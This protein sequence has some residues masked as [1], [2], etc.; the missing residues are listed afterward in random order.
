[1]KGRVIMPAR[2]RGQLGPQAYL[3]Q[4]QDRCLALWTPDEFEKQMADMERLQEQG[5]AERNLA[6]LWASST[7]DVDI[8]R[9]GRMAIPAY[10]REFAR[11]E[12]AVLVVGAL[13]RVELWSPAEWESRVLPAELQLTDETENADPEA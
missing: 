1:V 4:Y 10:L 13:N 3:S 8:D 9:Q 2:F 6:R 12:S 11:L 5:R 7:T